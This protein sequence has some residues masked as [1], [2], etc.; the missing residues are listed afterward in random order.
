[1]IDTF[2][3]FVW[4]PSVVKAN[5]ITAATEAACLVLSVDETVRTLTAECLG[6]YTHQSP[7]AGQG[8]TGT[9]HAKLL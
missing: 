3:S 1:M 5:A 2:E 9:L 6:R 7:S 8:H 4:E